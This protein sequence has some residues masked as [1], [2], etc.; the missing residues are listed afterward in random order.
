MEMATVDQ[1]RAHTHEVAAL[2]EAYAMVRDELNKAYREHGHEEY[3]DG[4]YRAMQLLLSLHDKR[5]EQTRA[6]IAE[7]ARQ[8]RR[9]LR[10][11]DPRALPAVVVH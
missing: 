7:W 2:Y 10:L 6:E 3:K 9:D 5:D 11:S 1:V 8:A 4:L